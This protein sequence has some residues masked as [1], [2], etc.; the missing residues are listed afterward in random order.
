M[1]GALAVDGDHADGFVEVQVVAFPAGAVADHYG[2][3]GVQG[4]LFPFAQRAAVARPPGGGG[5]QQPG[6]LGLQGAGYVVAI[7]VGADDD[8]HGEV[9]A[10]AVGDGDGRNFPAGGR[11][12][13][14]AAQGFDF[15]MAADDV[16]VGA[17]DEHGV[18]HQAG[19]RVPFRVGE[20]H[21]YAVAG[22]LAAE[23]AHPVVGLGQNP[24]GADNFGEFVAGDEQ[25]RRDDPPGAEGGGPGQA[26][27]GQGAVMGD[28]AHGRGQ[29]EQSH[30]QGL[31]FHRGA[32]LV[33][34]LVLCRAGG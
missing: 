10:A 11:P 27:L 32:A 17:D 24:V 6:A 2:Q 3:A 20:E 29:V 12:G 33:F 26:P 34:A 22:G 21:R 30:A 15:A 9:A 18:V 23:V 25:L 28:G 4:A 7:G 16:P 8:A 14:G 19:L 5:D 13:F 31:G 1:Q